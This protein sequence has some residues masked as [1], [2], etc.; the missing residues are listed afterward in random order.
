EAE[1][2]RQARAPDRAGG[3]SRLERVHGPRARRR[4]RAGAAV[5]LRDQHATAKAAL[6]E[7]LLERREVAL[8]DRQHVGVHD[9]GARALV[10]APLLRERMRDRDRDTRQFLGEDRRRAPLV[11]RRSEERRVGKEWRPRWWREQ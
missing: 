3:G 8:D 5:G 1:Q 6:G 11:D 7:P 10:L 9:G 4:D 2:A